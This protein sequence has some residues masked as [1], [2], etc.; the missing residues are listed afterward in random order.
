MDTTISEFQQ[1]GYRIE[2]ELGANRV[3]G[4]VTFLATDIQTK[5]KVVIKQFQF[6]VTTSDWA[7]FSTFEREIEVL[8]G[9]EHPAIPKYLDS[10]QT[11]NGF[12]I[13]QE[14]KKALSL[15]TTRSYSSGQVQHIAIAILEVLIYLQNRIPPIIHRDIKPDNILMD[16]DNNVYLVDFG[17]A[18]VGD[19]EVGVSS[20]V[21]GTLGFMPPEQL[22]NRQL[23]EASDLY[24]L[25]MTL[26]CLLTG[27]KADEIGNLVDISYKVKF[28][29]LIPK[30]SF[31]WF[32]WLEKMVEP[33]VKDRYPNAVAAL[34]RLPKSSIR[35]PEIQISQSTFDFS[36]RRLGEMLTQS[37]T[38]T[39][40]IPDTILEGKWEIEAR[41]SDL[42]PNSLRHRWIAVEPQNF[43]GSH[44]ECHIQ[45]HTGKLMADKTYRRK[46]LLRT[47][48]ASDTLTFELQV[49]TAPIPIHVE[50][51]AHRPLILLFL[52][53]LFIARGNFWLVS[54]A[55]FFAENLSIALF[56]NAIGG[57]L[58]L[59]AAAWTLA[60][61]G[62]STGVAASGI[63]GGILSL[64]ML[65][66][67]WVAL[68]SLSGEPQTVVINT[69]LGLTVSWILGIL[70]G[71]A[72]ERVIEQ[73]ASK[74]FSIQLVLLTVSSAISVAYAFSVGFNHLS[75]ILGLTIT[76]L[77]LVAL[78][79]HTPL[80]RT[81][82]ISS[83]RKRE[84][85]LVRL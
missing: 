40:P 54:E 14:Y 60:T 5:Q 25:G 69:I 64:V 43:E 4:R 30:L 3:G 31:H 80:R 74:A 10:F 85:H 56:S 20:V 65:L 70:T 67:S 49:K 59:E 24:G 53:S 57:V 22:F 28:K 35:L 34:E 77:P 39:N 21:K 18:R 45:V 41:S 32:R 2:R 50:Y 83:Y 23:T 38:I 11:Q 62:A 78:L 66:S 55:G 51:I 48:T 81:R 52:A 7:N 61:T 68:D 63:A 75:S 17:F 8:R 33:R 82:L 1:H 29:H 42:T 16:K 19:G 37:V 27:T 9:L 13:I 15:S 6:A 72:A 58:G 79:V 46:L 12:C 47:N 44:A 36:A 76:V 71:I 84:R 26:I 73:D